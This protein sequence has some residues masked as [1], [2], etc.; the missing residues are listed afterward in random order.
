MMLGSLIPI[1]SVVFISNDGLVAFHYS[2]YGTFSYKQIDSKR[3]T[4][5]YPLQKLQEL[6]FVKEVYKSD[7]RKSQHIMLTFS[8]L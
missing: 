1:S 4:A 7:K 8:S 3:S 5:F 6:V 2:S